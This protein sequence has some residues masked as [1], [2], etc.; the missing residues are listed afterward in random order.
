M[1]DWLYEN[2]G[3]KTIWLVFGFFGG[4]LALSISGAKTPLVAISSIFAGLCCATAFT[5]AVREVWQYPEGLEPGISFCLGIAGMSIVR[6][7]H[8]KVRGETLANIFSRW[9]GKGES[10]ERV[11]ADNAKE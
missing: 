9:T 4:I 2:Y 5:P 1:K 3:F 11:D 7:I 8:E 6:V 10:R